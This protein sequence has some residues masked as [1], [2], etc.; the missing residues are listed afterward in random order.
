MDYK[1]VVFKPLHNVLND[2][3]KKLLSQGV[4]AE[5]IQARV[6]TDVGEDMLWEKR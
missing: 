1:D 3:L 6:I 2:M 5:K 4:G